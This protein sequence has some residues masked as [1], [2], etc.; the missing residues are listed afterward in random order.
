LTDGARRD[1]SSAFSV[2]TGTIAYVPNER[3]DVQLRLPKDLI[4]DGALVGIFRK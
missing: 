2:T 3:I 1:S 4:E